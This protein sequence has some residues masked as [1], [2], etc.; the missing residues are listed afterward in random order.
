MSPRQKLLQNLPRN[1]WHKEIRPRSGPG[2]F[3][4]QNMQLSLQFAPG[5]LQNPLR[6]GPLAGR[7][8]D[9]RVWGG[10]WRPRDL[11]HEG[12]LFLAIQAYFSYK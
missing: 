8:I 2:G 9:L 12:P 7:S 5:I 1:L 4:G 6:S 11:N 3:F 10:A